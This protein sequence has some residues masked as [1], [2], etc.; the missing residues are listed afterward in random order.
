MSPKRAKIGHKMH[1]NS[2]KVHKNSI[3]RIPENES[4]KIL[5]QIGILRRVFDQFYVPC[6]SARAKNILIKLK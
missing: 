1:I 3:T 6:A 2:I 4:N 5:I